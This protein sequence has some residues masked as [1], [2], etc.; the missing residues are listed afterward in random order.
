M[1]RQLGLTWR[2]LGLHV[3]KYVKER[4]FDT[5]GYDSSTKAID[6][7]EIIAKIKKQLVSVVRILMYLYTPT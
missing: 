2:E 1:M 4:G 5:C 6:R 7:A 3:A